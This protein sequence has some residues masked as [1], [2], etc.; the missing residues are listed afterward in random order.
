MHCTWHVACN[1]YTGMLRTVMPMASRRRV[2]GCAPAGAKEAIEPVLMSAFCLQSNSW[3]AQEAVASLHDP[4]RMSWRQ[5]K[6]QA[7]NVAGQAF[8]GTLPT[9]DP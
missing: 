6:L 5:R 8:P 3:T 1:A 9:Q 2:Q 4:L 7:L